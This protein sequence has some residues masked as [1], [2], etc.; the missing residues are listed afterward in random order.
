VTALA[1]LLAFARAIPWQLWLVAGALIA[2]GLYGCHEYDRGRE[3]AV[4]TIT[5]SNDRA[6]EKADAASKRV[7]DCV[8]VWD[9]ARGVCVLGRDGAGR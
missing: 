7:E 2:G 8:G 3:A 5:K 1:G 9:R 4:A 6:K